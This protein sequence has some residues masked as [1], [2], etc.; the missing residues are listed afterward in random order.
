MESPA[1]EEEEPQGMSSHSNN[2]HSSIEGHQ[3]QH[4]QVSQPN[5]DGVEHCLSQTG[6]KMGPTGF[7]EPVRADPLKQKSHNENKYQGQGVHAR[8]TTGPF[9]KQ[10]QCLVSPEEGH[11][12]HAMMAHPIH[13]FGSVHGG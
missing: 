2:K 10:N 1:A 6:R 7:D 9:V 11:V 13:S 4:N 12:R 5:S 3:S 8:T